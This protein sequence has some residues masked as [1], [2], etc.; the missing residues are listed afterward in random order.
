MNIDIHANNHTDKEQINKYTDDASFA[1]YITSSLRE[2]VN[3]DKYNVFNPI[4]NWIKFNFKDDDEMLNILDEKGLD[5][6]MEHIKTK[7]QETVDGIDSYLQ[8]G[9]FGGQGPDD[10]AKRQNKIGRAHV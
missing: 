4:E 8:L 3:A 10:I 6:A 2:I 5:G 9:D 1:K 7:A